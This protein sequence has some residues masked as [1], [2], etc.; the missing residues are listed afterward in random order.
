[1]CNLSGYLQSIVIVDDEMT[2]PCQAIITDLVGH[3][4]E[5]YVSHF[6]SPAQFWCQLVRSE[7][8]LTCLSEQLSDA[9]LDTTW[10]PSVGA[11]CVARLVLC[12]KMS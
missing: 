6:V 1:M 5:V 12:L 7:A 2:N 9:S 8:Q 4:M 11:L 10:E 3:K